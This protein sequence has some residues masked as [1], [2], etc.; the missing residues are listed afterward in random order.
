MKNQIVA[1]TVQK[2]D[3]HNRR[4]DL[5]INTYLSDKNDKIINKKII[6]S[7]IDILGKL[8]YL[9]FYS[10]YKLSN[11]FLFTISYLDDDEY[12]DENDNRDEFDQK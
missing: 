8:S 4:Y 1:Y 12:D 10:Y 6:V 9:D 5:E 3:K 7:S 2:V 11:M